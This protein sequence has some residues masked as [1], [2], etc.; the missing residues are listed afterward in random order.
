MECRAGAGKCVALY[1]DGF[2]FGEGV[3]GIQAWAVYFVEITC[4]L[5]F[6]TFDGDVRGYIRRGMT[7]DDGE[8]EVLAV[9]VSSGGDVEVWRVGQ[10]RKCVGMHEGV[11]RDI[12]GM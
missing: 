5:Q 8:R 11:E 3:C 10:I 4:C 2:R 7:I 12:A 6:E 9:V 1:A